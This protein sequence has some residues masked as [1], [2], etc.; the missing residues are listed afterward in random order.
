MIAQVMI[1]ID[2]LHLDRPFDYLVPP[3]LVSQVKVGCQVQVRW[4]NRRVS[5]WVIGLS[6]D[7]EYQG[8]LQKIQ[9][10]L[11][12]PVISSGT[13]A[14]LR[15]L[16]DKYCVSMAQLIAQAVPPRHV[17][18]QKELLALGGDRRSTET[19]VQCRDEGL[20]AIDQMYDLQ[21]LRIGASQTRLRAAVQA[22]PGDKF[23]LLKDLIRRHVCG[24]QSLVVVTP[25][26]AQAQLVF[27]SA[28]EAFS[29]E[30]PE[31]AFALLL[32]E[33]PPQKRFDAFLRAK[34][35]VARIIVGTR[36]AAW[37][38]IESGTIV[39]WDEGSEHLRERRSPYLDALDIAVARSHS[40][41]LSL[42]TYGYS[43][44][45]K[46]Q[47]LVESGWQRPIA[48]R[49]QVFR[50]CSPKIRTLDSDLFEREGFSALSSIPDSAKRM[51]TDA[52]ATGPALIQTTM[53]QRIL[54]LR[55]AHCG[56]ENSCP[57]CQEPLLLLAREDI[58]SHNGAT[59]P[60]CR[61]AVSSV[62]CL[63]CGAANPLKIKHS[64]AEHLGKELGQMFPGIPVVVS[65]AA[66]EIRRQISSAP[67]IVVAT[68]GAEPLCRGGYHCVVVTDI[69]FVLS[70][71][72]LGAQMEAMRRWLAAFGLCRPGAI[73]ALVG[74]VPANLQQALVLFRPDIFAAKELAEREEVGFFP[75]RWIV[76]VE[77][78][79]GAV[80]DVISALEEELDTAQTS[81]E[82]LGSFALPQESSEMEDAESDDALFSIPLSDS[83]RP[84]RTLISSSLSGASTLMREM[85]AILVARALNH[86]T[87]VHL[88]VN[89]SDVL[90]AGR[91]KM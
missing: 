8:E 72:E 64:G 61:A 60:K 37:A 14:T 17:R 78:E 19:K 16:A 55:C 41:G 65:T 58:G 21:G 4:G 31:S 82:V 15:Y 49:P 63:Q 62:V 46:V 33:D 68:S 29:E 75:A 13:F 87:N 6:A 44:S 24:S 3:D 20:D 22:L 70:L 28:L 57:S 89:P 90:P 7:S 53:A 79:T 34:L 81:F 51:L 11:T 36:A 42:I 40:E 67:Q 23:A 80:T 5:G 77:G 12:I 91:I 1:D 25:T 84:I 35:G 56:A 83:Q 48:A 47:A 50:Q 74:D 85:R 54:V 45:L 59:C 71:D 30:I 2:A 76:A 9:R 38:P 26:A 52:L 86:E 27:K 18:A 73:C 39:L 69:S 43:R 10:C 88:V 66:N 32:A